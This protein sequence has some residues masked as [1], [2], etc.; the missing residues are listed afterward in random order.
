MTLFRYAVRS[1]GLLQSP[2][3]ALAQYRAHPRHRRDDL[4]R[5]DARNAAIHF[6]DD[7]VTRM[8]DG[9]GLSTMSL[10]PKEFEA[11]RLC[12]RPLRCCP[13]HLVNGAPEQLDDLQIQVIMRRDPADTAFAINAQ[14]GAVFGPIVTARSWG[15]HVNPPRL[16]SGNEASISIITG[17]G[18]L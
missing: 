12:L 8:R 1:R 11:D 9:T 13:V 5:T 4:S 7:E 17:M 10:P 3:V 14:Q 18:R 15:N 6:S 2:P 16:A